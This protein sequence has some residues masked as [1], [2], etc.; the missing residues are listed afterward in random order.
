MYNV[1]IITRIIIKVTVIVIVIMEPFLYLVTLAFVLVAI[2]TWTKMQVTLQVPEVKK[3]PI[4]GSVFQMNSKRHDLSLLQ[5]AKELGPIYSVQIFNQTLVI[6]SGYGDVYEML[7]SKGNSFAGRSRPFRQE[8][9]ASG[10]KDIVNGNP[11]LPHWTPL[12]KAAHRGIR[13]YGTWLNRLESTLSLM[14]SDFVEKVRSYNGQSVD[15][16]EDIYNYVLKV[17]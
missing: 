15:L 4:V 2:Y 8:C 11:T 9:F 5:W 17:F 13:H 7:V 10:D 14:V 16:R 6:V 1:L 12:R 3:W